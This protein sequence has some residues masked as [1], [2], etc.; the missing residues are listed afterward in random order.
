VRTK[1]ATV[2]LA[3]IG[4]LM[5]SVPVF[6]HHGNAAFDFDKTVTL[7]GTVTEWIYA[8]PHCFVKL[9]A[10]D[11]KGEMQHWTIETGAAAYYTPATGWTKNVL[12]AGDEITI[13][14]MPVKNGAPIG[15]TRRLIL[16]D[17]RI[18]RGDARYTI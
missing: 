15:R 3:A 7:K 16:P 11:E 9:D 12:K 4:L 1:L 10:K 13:E 6:A 17:G 8:N 14:I 5:V 18:L 2:L